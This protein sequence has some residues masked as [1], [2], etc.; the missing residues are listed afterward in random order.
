MQQAIPVL[1]T[2]NIKQTIQFYET[3]LGF[4]GVDIGGYAIL[5]KGKAE[6][7]F[8]LCADKKLCEASSC[9]I[10]VTDVQCLFADFAGKEII[11]PE[12]KL[13]HSKGNK[14]SFT[15]KDN[16]GILLRFV[17]ES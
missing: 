4:T 3:E 14:K 5:K 7:H 15:L 1:P 9:Y 6:I 11:Y 13:V 17:Q 2:L 16:N 10:R 12:N 8:T